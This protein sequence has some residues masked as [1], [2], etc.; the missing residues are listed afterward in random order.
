MYRE[1][2]K[3]YPTISIII[4]KDIFLIALQL[5]LKKK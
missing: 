2:L 4:R 3:R 5:G 1:A